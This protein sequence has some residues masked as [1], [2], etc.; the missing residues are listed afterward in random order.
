MIIG[1]PFDLLEIEP[2]NDKKVIKKAYAKMVKRYHP[3]EFPEEWK[4]IH[5]AYE[6]AISRADTFAGT[7]KKDEQTA[8]I[9]NDISVN[10]NFSKK[11]QEGKKKQQTEKKQQAEKKRDAESKQEPPKSRDDQELDGVFEHLDELAAENRRKIYESN[12]QSLQRAMHELEKLEKEEKYN[13]R[14]W[15]K[16]F[17]NEDYVWAIKQDAFITKWGDILRGKQIDKECHSFMKRQ[18][19]EIEQYSKK[20]RTRGVWDAITYTRIK[21]DSAYE[22]YLKK[23]RVYRNFGITVCLIMMLLCS[24][25][26][27]KIDENDQSYQYDREQIF[28]EVLESNITS[29]TERSLSMMN[30][31]DEEQKQEWLK[32][33]EQIHEGMYLLDIHD[34]T[35]SVNIEHAEKQVESFMFSELSVPTEI[36][37]MEEKNI[38]EKNFYAFCIWASKEHTDMIL[39]CDF[40]KL[41]IDDD[42]RVYY[43]DGEQY[44]EIAPKNESLDKTASSFYDRRRYEMIGYQVFVVDVPSE[45]EKDEKHPIVFVSEN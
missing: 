31:M 3:E 35:G 24:V 22:R 28:E 1:N 42:C 23:K 13:L 32:E 5:A 20:E 37:A 11:K 36:I 43:Y 21:I 14:E 40:S 26:Q 33:S 15:E 45:M 10:L 25:L 6:T 27:K 41:G 12:M 38:A 39:W 8:P 18:L 16:L 34:V 17:D 19:G 7:E 4:C 9:H 30:M 2:T 29:M 44:I